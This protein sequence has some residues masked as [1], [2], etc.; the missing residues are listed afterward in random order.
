MTLTQKLNINNLRN[1]K[2]GSSENRKNKKRI[3]KIYPLLSRTLI[4]LII[5]SGIAFVA[6]IND[7]SIKGFVLAELKNDL[8]NLQEENEKIE[9][10]VMAL[11]SYE[12]INERA[13]NLKMVRVDAIDYITTTDEAVAKR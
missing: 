2:T 8:A 7:L 3:K 5:L 11:E 10:S 6:S 9:L 12:S 4:V 1:Q 13:S